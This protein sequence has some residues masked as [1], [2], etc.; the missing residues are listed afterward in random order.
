MLP[1]LAAIPLGPGLP[2]GSSH[3]PA[4]TA[5]PA[6]ALAYLVLLRMEVA[7]FH[8][9]RTCFQTQLDSSLWPS[10]SCRHAGALPRILL[11]GARTF[12]HALRRSGCLAGSH[13]NFTPPLWSYGGGI[14]E[15]SDR[16]GDIHAQTPVLPLA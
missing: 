1:A 13:G 10:S 3:L 11:F 7:A 9:C 14:E 2:Q 4:S 6:L 5:E 16:Q 15:I 8:P 12:L